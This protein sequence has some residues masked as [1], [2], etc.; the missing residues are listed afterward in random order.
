MQPFRSLENPRMGRGR[1]VNDYHKRSTPQSRVSQPLYG[2]LLFAPPTLST[3]CF[4]LKHVM[5][6][7]VSGWVYPGEY[8][9][10]REVALDAEGVSRS[11]PAPPD[12]SLPAFEPLYKVSFAL[13][14]RLSATQL[15]S[16]AALQFFSRVTASELL[17][18]RGGSRCRGRAPL[19]PR[20]PGNVAACL[21]A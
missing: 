11:P 19:S 2:E 4:F 12:T 15:L 17:C 1:G 10:C 8:A 9:W 16:R 5:L 20:P 18:R 13:T 21:I 6:G 3:T 7:R 14:S